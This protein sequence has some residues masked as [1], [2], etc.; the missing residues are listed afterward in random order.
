[1]TTAASLPPTFLASM[2]SPTG[3]QSNGMGSA[4]NSAAPNNTVPTPA[5]QRTYTQEEFFRFAQVALASAYSE[6]LAR[7]HGQSRSP[8]AIPRSHSHPYLPRSP[9]ANAAQQ[10]GVMKPRMH[11]YESISPNEGSGDGDTQRPHR[12]MIATLELPGLARSDITVT[13]R[14]DGELIIAGERH[15]G[16]IAALIGVGSEANSRNGKRGRTVFNELKFGRFQR[17]IRLPPGT[18]VRVFPLTSLFKL[19]LTFVLNSYARSQRRW[20]TACSPFPGLWPTQLQRRDPLLLHLIQHRLRGQL[21]RRRLVE[22]R[23]A[24]NL[25][26]TMLPKK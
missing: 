9:P 18:D 8:R 17:S 3:S 20:T 16:R 14:P 19:S 22:M 10:N 6:Q 1:M 13:A 7:T 5:A 25:R 24:R 11:L 12:T 15:E 4:S 23:T 2:T 26:E 21:R